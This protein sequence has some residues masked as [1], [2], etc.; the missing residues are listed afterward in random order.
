MTFKTL[1]SETLF[2][3]RVF[4]LLREQILYPD[5]RKADFDILRHGGAVAILPINAEGEV[6]FVRQ[7][8]H[9]IAAHLVEIPAGRLEPGEDPLKCAARE[10]KEEIGLAPG[11]LEKL[12]DFYIAPGYS[13]EIIT[14]F[15]ATQLNPEL[16]PQDQDEEI[17]IIT[18][19]IT[20]AYERIE[21]GE[22]KDA[23]SILA[24]HLAQPLLANFI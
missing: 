9:A 3:G 21:A 5:G 4:D 18:M 2:K 23:K 10:L 17:E 7:Y 16:L 14:L 20:E 11:K 24:L 13:D 12:I 1:K 22:I 8:R 19:K 15:L 6:I